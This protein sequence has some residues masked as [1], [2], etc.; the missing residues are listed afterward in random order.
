MPSVTGRVQVDTIGSDYDTILTVF[1][2]T[3][4][5]PEV[6]RCSDDDVSWWGAA[7]FKAT[8][9]VEYFL[10]PGR[11]RGS[12]R[13][14]GGELV[15]NVTEVTTQDPFE[16]SVTV[17]GGTV[18]PDTGIVTLAGTVTCNHVS[19]LLADGELRQL[20]SERSLVG[21]GL[22][23]SGTGSTVC[24]AHPTSGRPKWIPRPESFSERATQGS[25]GG[26]IGLRDFSDWARRHSRG[27]NA[28]DLDLIELDSR[29]R[30]IE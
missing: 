3:N 23:R 22:V 1:R 8:A 21:A 28:R 6:I 16:A 20:R 25:A 4:N 13:R 29:Q 12:D 17:E 7:R 26:S 24:R 19:W 30:E 9:G 27:S 11:R 15:L 10:M 18:D 14:G 5:G 2:M